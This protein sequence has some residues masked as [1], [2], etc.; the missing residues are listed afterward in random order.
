[1]IYT[2]DGHYLRLFENPHPTPLPRGEGAKAAIGARV[3][4]LGRA[5]R[6]LTLVPKAAHIACP[7]NVPPK[8]GD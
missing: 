6:A 2:A 5:M 3:E 4:Y 7:T 8:A 1:M